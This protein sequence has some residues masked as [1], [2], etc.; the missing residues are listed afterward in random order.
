M[1]RS[2]ALLC[3]LL[4]VSVSLLGHFGLHALLGDSHCPAVVHA[5]GA[6]AH[7]AVAATPHEHSGCRHH[8]AVESEPVSHTEH[9]APQSDPAEREPHA[10][11][12]DRHDESTCEICSV[13]AQALTAPSEAACLPAG[14]VS[15]ETL[16]ELD[17]APVESIHAAYESRGPPRC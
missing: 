16:P 7:E 4:Q 5:A 10:P 12:D 9:T 14:T 1:F 11:A 15:G 8:S 6:D 2:V 17:A 3:A 13:L